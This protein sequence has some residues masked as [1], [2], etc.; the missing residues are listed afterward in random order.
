MGQVLRIPRLIG[1]TSSDPFALRDLLLEHGEQGVLESQTWEAFRADLRE[2]SVHISIA[3]RGSVV[4]VLFQV[5]EPE[6]RA[7]FHAHGDPVF[8]DSCVEFFISDAEGTYLNVECNPLGAV[9]SGI[10]RS[11]HERLRMGDDFY[12]RLEVWTTIDQSETHGS[13]KKGAWESLLQIPLDVVFPEHADKA[14]KDMDFSGNLYKCGDLLQRPHYISWA[15]IHTDA[16]D[17]HQ[18]RFFG[19]FEFLA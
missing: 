2:V 16:P 17:F 11:R 6:I 4:L 3:Y 8:K 12:S 18:S 14:L 15:P 9:L 13:P 5:K 19:K 7:T 1:S 10:G